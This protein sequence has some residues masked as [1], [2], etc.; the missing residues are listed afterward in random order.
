M[1]NLYIYGGA[2]DPVTIGHETIILRMMTEFVDPDP[3]ACM[4]VL[5]SNN[6]TKQ[7]CE[8]V[9][10]RISMMYDALASSGVSTEKIAVKQQNERTAATMC[11]IM[12][13][14]WAEVNMFIDNVEKANMFIDNV[15]TMPA[16]TPDLTARR[17]VR[18]HL[19]I[20]IDEWVSLAINKEWVESDWILKNANLV[21]VTRD[22]KSLKDF[23]VEL[24]ANW[25]FVNFGA[26]N[27]ESSKIRKEMLANPMSSPRGISPLVMY[28]IRDAHL[29]GQEDP[30]N[31]TED[32]KLS[33]ANYDPA[34]YPRPSV[35]ATV[36]IYDPCSHRILIVRRKDFPYRNYWA[37]PGGFAEKGEPI[38]TVAVRETKEE[39]GLDISQSDVKVLKVFLPDD[40]RAKINPNV[41]FYDVALLVTVDDN[42]CKPIA[43]DDAVD[44]KWVHINE[45]RNMNLAFHHNKIIEEIENQC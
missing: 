36:A 4:L 15:E 31:Y 44:A 21:V 7:Y 25:T 13:R 22:G 23:P 16:V 43:G 35:T 38:E 41:W 8:N 45:A 6:D 10:N 30:A 14:E 24:N 33:L 3:N 32:E 20:G 2:F 5:V 37:L 26:P 29:Y 1:I 12:N 28:H 27:T 40:P 34:K 18:I 11:K 39:T 9:D 42:M 17:D 19:V